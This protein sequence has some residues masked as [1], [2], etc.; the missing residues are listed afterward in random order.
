MPEHLLASIYGLLALA[1]GAA[2]WSATAVV[3][4]VWSLP[5]APGLGWLIGWACR[6]GGRRPDTFIR[7]LA[8]LLGFAGTVSALFVSS[9]FSVTQASPDSGFQLPT[10]ALEFLRL[11]A[12]PPWF[13]SVAILAALSGTWVSLRERDAGRATLRRERGSVAPLHGTDQRSGHGREKAS[14]AKAA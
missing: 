5:A 6:H 1:L 14:G 10:V 3:F 12:E 9:S 11:F 4:G 2:V 13:G 8:W 7:S